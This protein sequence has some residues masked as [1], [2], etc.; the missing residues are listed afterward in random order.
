M[1][2]LDGVLV[3]GFSRRHGHHLASAS[4][5]NGFGIIAE[6]EHERRRLVCWQEELA[7][8]VLVS[9]YHFLVKSPQQPLEAGAAAEE[10]PA[11]TEEAAGAGA[12]A[13]EES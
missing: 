11:A 1:R 7:H 5:R 9:V 8:D 2:L 6:S 3:V 4:G 10:E 12:A 13:E